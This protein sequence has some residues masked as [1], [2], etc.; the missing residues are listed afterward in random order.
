MNEE[1]NN[2]EDWLSF[3]EKK[4]NLK[5]PLAFSQSVKINHHN[6]EAPNVA[7]SDFYMTDALVC[8]PMNKPISKI[9]KL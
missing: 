7:S 5:I 2:I 8:H 4:Y 1:K 6:R 9:V 3:I